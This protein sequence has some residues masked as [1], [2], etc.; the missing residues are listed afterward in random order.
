MYVGDNLL[1]TCS[2]NHLTRECSLILALNSGPMGP[3]LMVLKELKF[4]VPSSVWFKTASRC[5]INSYAFSH[6]KCGQCRTSQWMISALGTL[7]QKWNWSL[8]LSFSCIICILAGKQECGIMFMVA[9]EWAAIR[10]VNLWTTFTSRLKVV[11]DHR[12]MITPEA[13]GWKIGSDGL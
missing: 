4:N 11:S 13:I 12:A 5:D 2:C 10:G 1:V 3:W 7:G 8:F 6:E 9:N